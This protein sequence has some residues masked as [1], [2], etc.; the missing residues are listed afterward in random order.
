MNEAD[1]DRVD[2]R[3]RMSFFAGASWTLLVVFVIGLALG[4]TEEVRPGAETDV[5]NVTAISLIAFGVALFA[6]L[7]VYAPEGSVRDV[8]G[9]RGVPVQS[10]ILAA[11]LGVG[12]HPILSR[13]DDLLLHKFPQ[14]P[15]VVEV[16]ARL[17]RADTWTRRGALALALAI[18]FPAV[19]ETFFR[20]ALFGTMKRGREARIVAVVVAFYFAT[21]AGDP[22]YVPSLFAFGVVLGWLRSRTGSVLPTLVAHVAFAAVPVV[23][24]LAGRDPMADVRYSSVLLLGGVALASA[25]AFGLHVLTGADEDL[26]AHRELDG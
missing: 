26:A 25:A 18:V 16:S 14:P 19:Q 15:E 24:I 20:G 8:F 22:R 4:I 3:R 10:L 17:M 7:R 21:F 6:I 9:I 2:I 1:D 13:V 5:V 11:G 12:V 23:P